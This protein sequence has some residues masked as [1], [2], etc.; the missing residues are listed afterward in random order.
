MNKSTKEIIV[1]IFVMVAIL[2]VVVVATFSLFGSS[3]KKAYTQAYSQ[4]CAKAEKKAKISWDKNSI[5]D[6][7]KARCK[8]S[9]FSVRR[10]LW[11]RLLL[12][13]RYMGTSKQN[14][15]LLGI[16]KT[17]MPMGCM[18]DFLKGIR[19]PKINVPEMNIYRQSKTIKGQRP[20]STPRR[21]SVP[22]MIP[23]EHPMPR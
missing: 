1:A 10:V 12:K 4:V 7:L 9:S 19:M 21:R 23:L 22:A 20:A 3:G 16:V 11:N 18:P 8:D 15:L 13:G 2:A 6:Q 5:V 17:F 14:I